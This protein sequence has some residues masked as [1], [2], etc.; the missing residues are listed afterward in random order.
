MRSKYGETEFDRRRACGIK[1][2]AEVADVHF[3]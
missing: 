1:A 2:L 3:S